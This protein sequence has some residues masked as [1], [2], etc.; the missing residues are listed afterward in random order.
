MHV[1]KPAEKIGCCQEWFRMI[2]GRRAGFIF[3]SLLWPAVLSTDC[4]LLLFTLCTYTP[5]TDSSSPSFGLAFGLSFIKLAKALSSRFGHNCCCFIVVYISPHYTTF[6]CDTAFCLIIPD[7]AT[8]TRR[9]PGV[10]Y[11]TISTSESVSPATEM[12][13]M[14][15]R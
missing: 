12:I 4:S 10:A 1:A 13:P 7:M 15:P 9:V 2:L 6:Y 8:A 11:T 14:N 5:S 3:S